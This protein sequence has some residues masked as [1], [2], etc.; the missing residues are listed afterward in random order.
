MDELRPILVELLSQLGSSR[1]AREYL[2]RFSSVD[3]VQFAVVK[4]GGGVLATDQEQL[5]SSLGFLRHVGLFPIVLHGAGPQLDSALAE[6]GIQAEIVDGMRVTSAEV[7]AAVR[8]VIY[9]QNL[10]LVE[11]LEKSGIR[12]RSLLHGVFEA[13]YLD[14]PRYGLV[15]DVTEVKKESL[16]AAVQA[17]ALPVVA[18][19]GESRSGQVLNINADVA[20]RALVLAVKPY[21][22]IFLTSTGGMLDEQGQVISA[23]NLETDYDQLMA[24]DWVHSGMRLK[25]VQIKYLLDQLPKSTSVSITSAENLTR[26]LFTHRGSGTLIRR[27]EEFAALPAIDAEQQTALAA[28]LKE[29]FGRALKPDYFAELE[30]KSLL[31]SSSRRAAAVMVDGL[32]AIPYMDKFAVTPTAQGEGLGTALWKQI[33]AAYPRLYWRSRASNPI[34]D[35]YQ[36]HADT[37]LRQGP[38]RVFSFGISDGTVIARCRD[39]AAARPESW[40]GED[41]ESSSEQ[42]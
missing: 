20:A 36:R 35:W 40:R 28:L 21:K 41:D 22:V 34:N 33:R 8:P 31:W 17:G 30:L 2:R 16:R 39:E 3:S 19:L 9:Q 6:A 23:I 14:A 32:D 24:A 12:A 37:S 18:C 29:C 10:K 13:D 1:E 11:A 42:T 5:V 27:G 25:I 15:G 26:E 38:W 4:V 7:M